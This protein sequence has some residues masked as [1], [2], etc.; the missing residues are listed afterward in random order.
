MT[1]SAAAPADLAG[2][3]IELTGALTPARFVESD[4]AF[5]LGMAF[6]AAQVAPPGVYIAMNGIVFSAAKVVR[7]RGR[8]AFVHRAEPGSHI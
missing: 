3:M 2:K 5:N 7:D 1:A 4:A 8:G 6:A